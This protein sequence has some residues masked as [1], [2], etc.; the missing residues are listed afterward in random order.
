MMTIKIWECGILKSIIEK[1]TSHSRGIWLS[2]GIPPFPCLI[3][4]T[5]VESAI[6]QCWWS[7]S[8]DWYPL[9]IYFFFSEWLHPFRTIHCFWWRRIARN[10]RGCVTTIMWDSLTLKKKQ[11]YDTLMV[12]YE[13]AHTVGELRWILMIQIYNFFS[14]WHTHTKLPPGTGIRVG[15]SLCIFLFGAKRNKH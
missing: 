4:I 9:M 3:G 15:L 12:L 8:L 6:K 13:D 7:Y 1:L 11:R 10:Q 5:C 2:G 14:W